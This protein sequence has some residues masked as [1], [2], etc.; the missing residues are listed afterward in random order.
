MGELWGKDVEADGSPFLCAS[1]RRAVEPLEEELEGRRDAFR[2]SAGLVEEEVHDLVRR[3]IDAEEVRVACVERER[4]EA[5]G[6]AGAGHEPR[7]SQLERLALRALGHAHGE[8]T[9]DL[10][11]VFVAEEI[12]LLR[13]PSAA[14]EEEPRD[15]DESL[16]RHCV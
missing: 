7:P 9:S 15:L 3:E 16:D 6:Q 4:N 12:A 8:Q 5:R 11:L 2:R 10:H 13:A 14:G 1:V